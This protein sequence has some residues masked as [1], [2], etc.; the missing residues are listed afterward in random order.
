MRT[1]KYKQKKSGFFSFPADLLVHLGDKF[2]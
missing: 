2:A 1:D